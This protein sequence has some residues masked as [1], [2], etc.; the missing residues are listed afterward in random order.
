M[1]KERSQKE[2][3]IECLNDNGYVSRNWCLNRYI[4]RLSAIIYNLKK[5]GWEFEEK[6]DGKNY[7]YKYTKK[8][9][10]LKSSRQANLFNY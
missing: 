1:N 9:E 8:P 4:S 6:W 10:S 2:I 3:I 7:V 5:D